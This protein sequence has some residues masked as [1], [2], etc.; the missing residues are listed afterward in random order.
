MRRGQKV[1]AL[2]FACFCIGLAACSSAQKTST[3]PAGPAATRGGGRW[4][5]ERANKWSAARGW[6]V[7]V[8][9]IPSTA[10]NQLE[11]WQ[12]DTFD[13]TTID[14]ELGWADSLGLT[15]V[16][17]FLHDLA[18]KEDPAG[19]SDRMEKFLSIAQKHKLGTMSVI[20]DLVWYP[21]PH[22]GK[23]PEPRPH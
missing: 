21:P 4:S 13:P 22:A 3:A 6:R 10:V 1:G 20:F 9:Y 18:W 17:V 11:M 2:R 14:R 19:F 5:E 8:N 15:S 12:A 7:G 23:Q 16:R